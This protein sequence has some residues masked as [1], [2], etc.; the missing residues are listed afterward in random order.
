MWVSTFACK[1]LLKIPK[2]PL[3]QQFHKNLFGSNSKYQVVLMNELRLDAYNSYPVLIMLF[4]LYA[5]FET[6]YCRVVCHVSQVYVRRFWS[7][8]YPGSSQ[9][10]CCTGQL[11]AATVPGL[12]RNLRAPFHLCIPRCH[13]HHNTCC[14]RTS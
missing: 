14:K 7:H 13:K 1:F 6:I 9:C 10:Q 11:G 12:H 8:W 3:I 5:M 4:Y 2:A